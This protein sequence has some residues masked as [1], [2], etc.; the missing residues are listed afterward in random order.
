MNQTQLNSPQT[1]Q[2]SDPNTYFPQ[3]ILAVSR[4]EYYGQDADHQP[5]Q[6]TI[7]DGKTNQ[8]TQLPKDLQGH[9]FILSPVGSVVSEAVPAPSNLTNQDPIVWSSKDGWTPLYNGDGMIYKLSFNDQTATLKTRL[10]K[11]PCYYADEATADPN[12]DYQELAFGDLGISRISFDKLGVRNQVNTA[13]LPFQTPADDNQRLLVTW[14]VGRPHEL[15]P[16]TLDTLQPVGKSGDWQGM[17]P[18]P[19]QPFKQL[20]TSAHPCFDPDAKKVYTI[21]VGKSLWTMFGLSRSIQARIKDNKKSIEHIE[22]TPNTQQIVVGLLK[23]YGLILGF[24]KSSIGFISF[25]SNI[26]QKFAKHNFVHLMRWD[27]QQVDIEQQWNILLPGKKPFIIDQ[28]THQMGL[29]EKYLIIAES[30]FKFSLENTLPYQRTAIINSF[31]I[32][33]ADFLTYPQFPDTKL[34]IIKRDDLEKAAQKSKSWLSFLSLKKKPTLP[35]A[36]AKEVNIKPEFSHYLVDYKNPNDRIILHA[37][38]LAASDIA[39]CIRIFDTSYYDYRDDDGQQNRYDDEILTSRIQKLAGNVVG[40]MDASR[41]GCWIIDGEK[42]EILASDTVCCSEKNPDFPLTWATAF[43]A[44]LDDQATE[45]FTDIYWNSWGAWPDLLTTRAAQ[46]YEY[47][48]ESASEEQHTKDP[49]KQRQVPVEEVIKHTY[50]GIPSSLCH[51]SIDANAADKNSPQVNLKIID[52]YQFKDGQN[53]Q[54]HVLGTSAQFI[55]RPKPENPTEDYNPQTYGYIAC[56]VLTSDKFFSE[57]TT[58][59]NWSQCSEIWIFDATNL[60][61]G[62][63]YKLSH[64]KMNFGFTVHTTWLKEAVS[65]KKM[66]YD[67]KDD[68]QDLVQKLMEKES[69]AI[70]KKVHKLFEEEIYPHFS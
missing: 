36:I 56:V 50:A 16:E 43:Y 8:E 10:A 46:Q 38:H 9:V 58:N 66:N 39:E 54:K 19:P 61:Q 35:V 32:W 42:A 63:L 64:P 5:L 57:P 53:S 11:P 62:P 22:K 30:S 40:P 28:T 26:S 7:K 27:G 25:F 55:P 60:E 14:D 44:Y 51:L 37:A 20:M 15:D 1:Y 41:L 17:L 12:K 3:T 70:A 69:P 45:K 68:Y 33:L 52:E 59:K 18:A 31:K 23:L 65:P 13:F 4:N 47:Y 24:L 2:N 29:T 49:E 34:Y 21:N 67:I 48:P 6:L